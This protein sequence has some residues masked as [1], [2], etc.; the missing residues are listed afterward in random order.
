MDAS[1][2]ATEKADKW[3]KDLKLDDE[4]KGKLQAAI[5]QKLEK[6]Q[7]IM[8]EKHKAMDALHEEFKTNLS[9]FLSADQLKQ[10]EEMK[11]KSHC[12]MCKDGKMCDMCKKMKEMHCPDCKDGK[13]CENCKKMMKGHKQHK[14]HDH[15][16][17]H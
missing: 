16:H 2:M 8:D 11:D 7:Q 4:Q 17:N 10:W 13:M 12:P 5:Q 3:A 9:G 15:G 14:N 6:K 1:A